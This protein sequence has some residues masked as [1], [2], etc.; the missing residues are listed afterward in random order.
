L[1]GGA[2]YPDAIVRRT[3]QESR[4]SLAMDIDAADQCAVDIRNNSIDN[5]AFISYSKGARTHFHV[6]RR[7][8]NKVQVPI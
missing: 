1:T 3:W 2:R 5:L 4:A 7:Q 8:S 6:E